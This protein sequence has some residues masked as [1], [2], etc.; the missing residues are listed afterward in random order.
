MP[1]RSSGS[2]CGGVLLVYCIFLGAL[3]LLG[4]LGYWGLLGAVI[5][6]WWVLVLLFLLCIAMVAW[7]GN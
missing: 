3:F 7:L 2:G 4:S 5:P 1:I 6:G